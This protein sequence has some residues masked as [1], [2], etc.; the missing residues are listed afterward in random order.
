MSLCR[1][2]SYSPALALALAFA[3]AFAP[4]FAFAAARA[5]TGRTFLFGAL[6]GLG[7]TCLARSR[8]CDC[9]AW[10]AG[11]DLGLLLLR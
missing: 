7:K 1:K 9:A 10:Q 4:A 11:N 6:S 3:L 2:G 5:V 8:V